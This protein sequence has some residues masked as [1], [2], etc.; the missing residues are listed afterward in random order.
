MVSYSLVF[1]RR[2]SAINYPYAAPNASPLFPGNTF[3][4]SLLKNVPNQS[5]AF[6]LINNQTD[7]A[8]VGATISG[9]VSLDG[10]PS[11]SIAGTV[12]E[13]GN[14]VYKY[15]PTQA[16]TNGNC[17]GFLMTGTAAGGTAVPE[18][19]VFLTNGLHRNVPNQHI[20]FGM[21][22][23]SGVLDTNAIISIFTSRD[24]VGQAPGA[25]VITNLG[26]GQYDYM[27]APTET[28]GVNVNMLATASG[29]VPWN[30]SIFTVP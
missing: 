24:G 6:A 7:T 11:A 9:F 26:N 21:I 19:F 2:P 28:A 12:S 17:V 29:D 5:F 14:G 23:T 15:V 22:A 27:F 4:M 1:R 10:R 16:E 8:M 20:I 13:L 30:I 25:G 18:S 3:D